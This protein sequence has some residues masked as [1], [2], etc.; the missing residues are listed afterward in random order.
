MNIIDVKTSSGE[1]PII[2]GCNIISELK[3]YTIPYDKILILSNEDIGDIYFE[4]LLWKLNDERIKTFT[5]PE[6]EKF[7]N[8]ET[9]STIYDFMAKENFSRKSLIISLGG[10]V[11]CDMGGFVGATY[12]RG[13]DFIQ[14]PTSLL[15]QVDASIGG[16]T[17]VDHPRGK[18]LIGVFKQPKAVLI[19]VEFL[20]TLPK[21]QFS[22]GMAEVIKHSLLLEN[23]DYFRFLMERR[24]EILSLESSSL[25]E[26]I[27]KSCEIKREIVEKDEFELG[28]RA[29][30]NLGHTYGHSLEKLFNFEN[31][32]HGEAVAKGTVFELELSKILNGIEGEF[33]NEIKDIFRSYGLNSNPIYYPEK[34]LLD[35]MKKDKKN[36]FDKI[37]FIL[38]DKNKKVYKDS[39]EAKNILE[40]N[41]LFSSRYIKG[42]IDIG[43]NSCRLFLAQVYEDREIK[44]EKE[45]S[46][47]VEIVKLGEDVNKNGYLKKE[48]IK[49]TI[50]CLKKYKE[51]A[52][53]F[54]ASKVIAFATSATRD[55]QNRE[56]FLSQVRDIGIDIRCIAG[57][58]EAQLNFLGNSIVFK[59]RILVLDIGGGSTEFTL[60]ENG[61][62]EFTKSINIGAVR[63]TERFFPEQ[64][65]T[66]EN[67][68]ECRNWIKEM[69]SGVK[70]LKDD[71]FTLV[72]VAGTATTQISVQKQME[73]YDSSEVH[74]SK[75]NLDELRQ[76]L[77]LFL[78]CDGEKRKEIVGLEAK[79]ADVIIAGTIILIAIME[80]LGVDSMV[81]SESDNLN[82]AMI[83]KEI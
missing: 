19:D 27:K 67:I 28:E 35:V 25:I 81:V 54:G 56:E 55:S 33:I 43:T 12:M 70:F 10:G 44:I 77:Q 57:E 29:L 63:G 18:N 41:N 9:I 80:E 2:L 34:I 40:V 13:I 7:K 69:V 65:Y 17:A 73:I 74:L 20:K 72:G 46:K 42:I 79:R 82:G 26:M 78:S 5:I 66:E 76:N 22:S 53:K 60:G 62:I 31:I 14:V 16:K 45:I 58:R 64:N 52:D 21:E 3:K 8:L 47:D 49:R 75:I 15:A 83:S 30:L 4:K 61:N 36:S 23:R 24:E 32:T 51:K 1:Y 59:D 39:V 38:F 48:A 68:E 11:V 6:G 71:N 37:N 50:D